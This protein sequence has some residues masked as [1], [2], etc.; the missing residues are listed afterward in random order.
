MAEAVALGAV[1][2]QAR[3]CLQKLGSQNAKK[4][5]RT[6]KYITCQV[7]IPCIMHMLPGSCQ[8]LQ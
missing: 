4:G 8:A 2:E 3:E 5:S 7:P 1:R 6:T